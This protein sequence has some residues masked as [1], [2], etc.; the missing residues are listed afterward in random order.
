LGSTIPT[1]TLDSL[2]RSVNHW[3]DANVI[4]SVMIVVTA[5]VTLVLSFH[6][7]NKRGAIKGWSY[8]NAIC[9]VLALI[10]TITLTTLTRSQDAEKDRLVKLSTADADKRIQRSKELA[11][12]ADEHAQIAT[13]Q[14]EKARAEAARANAEAERSKKERVALQ[15]RLQLLTNSNQTLSHDVTSLAEDAKP[16]MISP[17]QRRNLLRELSFAP[18]G[19]IDLRLCS[20]EAE[21]RHFFDQL[22][23]LLSKAG[24]QMTLTFGLGCVDE[25]LI[26]VLNTSNKTMV[27]GTTMGLL[28]AFQGAFANYGPGEQIDAFEHVINDPRDQRNITVILVGSKRQS[29]KG[30]KRLAN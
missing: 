30:Q 27:S 12:V 10:T 6:F 17:E 18:K 29:N 14:A 1:L 28:M 26:F 24:F 21:A 8:V 16:R 3:Q 19:P 22:S 5:I 25:G 9:S 4:L 7:G 11:A 13:E 20:G 2:S 23:S 15:V